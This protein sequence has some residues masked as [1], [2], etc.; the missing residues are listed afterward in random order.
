MAD[1]V[2]LFELLTMSVLAIYIDG[3]TQQIS[4]NSLLELCRLVCCVSLREVTLIRQ[5]T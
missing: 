1:E 4:Q 5:T 2:Q 3:D